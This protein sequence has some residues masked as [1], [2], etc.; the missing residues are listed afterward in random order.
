[1]LN[2]CFW[3]KPARGRIKIKNQKQTI[4]KIMPKE[5]KNGRSEEHTSELQSH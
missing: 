4:K 5:N 2:I 1:M 3:I